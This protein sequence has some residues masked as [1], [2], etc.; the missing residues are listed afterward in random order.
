MKLIKRLHYIITHGA[1]GVRY[2]WHLSAYIVFSISYTVD[3]FFIFSNHAR[4][5]VHEDIRSN[6]GLVFMWER[7]FE[8][9][10]PRWLFFWKR[11]HCIVTMTFVLNISRVLVGWRLWPF[12]GILDPFYYYCSQNHI[13]TSQFSPKFW[14]TNSSDVTETLNC[15][16]LSLDNDTE[17]VDHSVNHKFQG[18]SNGQFLSLFLTFAGKHR[19]VDKT[20]GPCVTP[21]TF[22]ILLCLLFRIIFYVWLWQSV[23]CSS[24]AAC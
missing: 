10:A 18:A 14:P 12:F 15:N 19:D 4:I 20:F 5:F 2:F 7:Y 23:T 3:S 21:F 9:C 11:R 16:I 24:Y 8:N 17:L 6:F 1:S 22:I 13:V